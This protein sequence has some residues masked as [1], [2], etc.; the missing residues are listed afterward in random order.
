MSEWIYKGKEMTSLEDF[1]PDIIGFVYLIEEVAT[2]MKYIGK[3][4]LYK[5]KIL[6]ATKTRKRRKRVSVES[7]WRTYHGSNK[8]LLE[9]ALDCAPGD[10]KR[11]ILHLCK[12]KGECSYREMEEQVIRKVLFR[13]DYYNGI[14]NCRISA[15]HLNKEFKEQIVSES[16]R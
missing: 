5:S 7:D 4:N 16:Y 10:F 1:G 12:T 8:T 9:R 14:I 15:V 2:G 3:K 13:D 6:P 11:E